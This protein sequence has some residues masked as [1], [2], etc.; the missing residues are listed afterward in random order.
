MY[1]LNV[2][3][4]KHWQ[5][6]H[7]TKWVLIDCSKICTPKCTKIY[8]LKFSALAHILGFR[9]KKASLVVRSPCPTSDIAVLFQLLNKKNRKQKILLH[10]WRNTSRRCM[11]GPIAGT[12]LL[13]VHNETSWFSSVIV[14]II[15]VC[16]QSMVP[17]WTARRAG[18]RRSSSKKVHWLLLLINQMATTIG[19]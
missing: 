11:A 15:F 17:Y 19:G 10:A 9:W 1:Y 4:G 16:I 7:S 13:T 14:C 5:G 12:I 8:L 3:N 18:F 6:T 2:I